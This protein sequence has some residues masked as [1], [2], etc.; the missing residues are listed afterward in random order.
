MASLVTEVIRQSPIAVAVASRTGTSAGRLP[1]KIVLAPLFRSKFHS[2]PRFSGKLY[3]TVLNE[4]HKVG[5]VVLVEDLFI[6][7]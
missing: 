4:E 5:G 3:A 2:L 7:L 6:V 1:R